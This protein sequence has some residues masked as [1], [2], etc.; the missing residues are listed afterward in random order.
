V[1]FGDFFWGMFWVCLVFIPLLC[2]W[3]FSMF[4]IFTR[5]MSGW[6]KAFW[7]CA[8]VFLPFV[9][10]LIYLIVRPGK[11]RSA[12]PQYA[13]N[14]GTGYT[15][16]AG[17]PYGYGYPYGAVVPVGPEAVPPQSVQAAPAPSP[18]QLS[19]L[20]RLHDD[21]KLTDAE[22]ASAKARLSAPASADGTSASAA[23]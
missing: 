8:V 22:F 12:A 17:Y 1:T 19:M 15:Y 13:Y 3:M 10:T 7:L 6:A 4:D 9:G 23:A 18:D 21:G 20:N 5:E 11:P 14:Y 2:V 16:G